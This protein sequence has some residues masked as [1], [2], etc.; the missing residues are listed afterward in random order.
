MDFEREILNGLNDGIQKSIKDQ[1]GG[2]NSPL[3]KMI[4]T[5]MNDNRESIMGK[6]DAALKSVIEN[7]DFKDALVEEFNRKVAKT[8]LSGLEGLVEK[9]ANSF[10][11]DPTIRAKMVM[12]IQAIIEK[13]EAEQLLQPDSLKDRL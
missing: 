3:T 5:V 12:A 1:M 7:P 2:Y 9:A 8:L 6:M 10:K 13:K 11:Q 4:E